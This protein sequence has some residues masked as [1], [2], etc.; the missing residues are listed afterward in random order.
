MNISNFYKNVRVLTR[1]SELDFPDDEIAILAQIEA[2]KLYELSIQQEHIEQTKNQT[3]TVLP[4]NNV[5][6]SFIPMDDHNL[7][8]ER[9]EYS[10]AGEENYSVLK[11]TNKTEYES[12][13]CSCVNDSLTNNL[14]DSGC[15]E[16]FIQTTQGIYVFPSGSTNIDVKVYVKDTPVIDWLDNDYEILIPNVAVD[17][18]MIATALMYRDIENTNEFNKLKLK[19][20]DLMSVHMNRLNKGSRVIKMRRASEHRYLNRRG[21]MRNPYGN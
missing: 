14:T 3:P 18:L 16:F 2:N 19:Y 7:W 17:L 11:R 15:T 12:F 8:I 13:G 10:R 5:S 9:V 6:D 20:D 4:F 21:N 1:S